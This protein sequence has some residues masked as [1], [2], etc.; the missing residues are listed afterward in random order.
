MSNEEL[1]KKV[2]TNIKDMT[3]EELQIALEEQNVGLFND[4]QKIVL[5][6]M[7]VISRQQELISRNTNMIDGLSNIVQKLQAEM[8]VLTEKSKNL[9]EFALIATGLKKVA[10]TDIGKVKIVENLDESERL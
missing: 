5:S 1:R 4:L 2:S 3:L 10:E 9:E 8:V 6:Q 7:D